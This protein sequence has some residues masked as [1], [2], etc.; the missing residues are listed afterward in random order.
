MKSQ[1][2]FRFGIR[3]SGLA[4]VG[5][6]DVF[7]TAPLLLALGFARSFLNLR[8]ACVGARPRTQDRLRWFSNVHANEAKAKQKAKVLLYYCMA[9]AQ[10]TCI[11]QHAC[12]QP[13]RSKRPLRN[14]RV[15][16]GRESSARVIRWGRKN[17]RFVVV[18]PPVVKGG[19]Y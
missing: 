5:A 10:L 19:D 7:V 8:G 3:C 13:Q 11:H 14:Q 16:C 17:A 9:A 4:F 1:R 2:C 6:D 12:W 15:R 18:V